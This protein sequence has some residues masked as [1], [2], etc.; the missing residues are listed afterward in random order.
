VDDLIADAH[1][2]GI[3]VTVDLVPNHTSDQHPWF[4]AALASP[5]GSPE[6]ARYHFRP[7]Q[8]TDGTEPPN[9]W[10]SV[11]GGSAWTRE[12]ARDAGPREWYLHLFSPAQPDLNW[13]NLEVWA[14]LDKTLRFWLDRGVDGFRIDAAHGMCKKLDDAGRP[15]RRRRPA[16]R[17]GR[18]ARRAPDDP[19]DA[20][21]LPGAGG[22]RRA[23]GA[24]RGPV[25]ALRAVGRAAPGRRHPAGREPVRRGRGA[26]RDRGLPGGGGLR[27]GRG[28]VVAVR[29]RPVPPRLPVRHGPG[30]AGPGARD[31]P[32]AARA[33][34]A[35][36]TSTTAT[37]WGCPT[38]PC[39]ARRAATP[40]GTTARTAATAAASRS[41]GRR[42]ARLRVHHRRALA[43]GYPRVRRPQRRR[44]ARGHRVPRS[45]CTGAR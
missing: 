44:A 42:P 13:T 30:R 11:F 39:P 5:T 8:G 9:G 17:P 21:P 31:G 10:R 16:V 37:S 18:R 14:D 34:P 4:R 20:R 23:R 19:C 29:P 27:G 35:R 38:P 7:G 26:R 33:S 15:R 41:P 3:R 12:P 40:S 25:R 43:A 36:R 6:R 24:Q 45:R 2:H 22:H 32:G 1:A 28:V